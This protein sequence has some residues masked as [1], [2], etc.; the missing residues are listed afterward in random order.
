MEKNRFILENLVRA[1]EQTHGGILNIRIATPYVELSYTDPM[2]H[3]TYLGFSEA[4]GEPSSNFTL[5]GNT[6]AQMV[7]DHIGCKLGED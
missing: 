2:G 3:I 5:I 6:L 1:L 7:E 4:Y